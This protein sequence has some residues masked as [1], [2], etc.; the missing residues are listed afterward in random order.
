MLE[1]EFFGGRCLVALDPVLS[2]AVKKENSKLT[3]VLKQNCLLINTYKLAE[4]I[5]VVIFSL[6]SVLLQFV[7]DYIKV[8]E[9]LRVYFNK[10]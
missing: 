8:K 5:D 4:S 9:F 1:G 6:P 7:P 3:V 2:K 10:K